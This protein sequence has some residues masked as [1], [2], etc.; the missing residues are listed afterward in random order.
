MAGLGNYTGYAPPPGTV[1]NDFSGSYDEWYQRVV[2]DLIRLYVEG[3]P[4]GGDPAGGGYESSTI[5]RPSYED[6][7]SA[8]KGGQGH[9][10]HATVQYFENYVKTYGAQSQW[11]KDHFGAPPERRATYNPDP[12]SPSSIQGT[13]AEREAAANADREDRQAFDAAEAEKERTFT[14]AEN[15]ADRK[16]SLDLDANATARVK[17]QIDSDWKIATMEDATRRY[18]AEGDWGT[19]KYIAELQETGALTRLQ[20]ELGQR[21]EELAQRAIEEKDRHHESMLALTLEVAKYDAE[22]SAQPRNWL[23]YAGW[24][25]T[26]NV[27]INGLTLAMAADM[28]PDTAIDP[29]EI[30]SSPAGGLTA[31]QTTSGNEQV[32]QVAPKTGGAQA[33]A[34]GLLSGASGGATGTS[35]ELEALGFKAQTQGAGGEQ[36]DAR[37]RAGQVAGIDLNSTDYSAIAR[38]LLGINTL[39]PQG[40]P[41]TAE[42]QAAYDATN[43]S[44]MAKTGTYG[45]YAGP[46]TNKFGMKINTQGGQEDY[47]NF[48]NLLPSQQDMRLAA[49]ESTGKWLPDFLQELQRSRPKGGVAGAASYG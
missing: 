41:S 45:A 29:G 18:I 10:S 47:R 8:K 14:A 19:Q 17:M 5:G 16:I 48:G 30:A 21:D 11:I 25:Q 31:L 13:Q 34:L 7:G 40:A 39:G 9:Y 44:G 38:K 27:V 35:T 28:V 46:T 2:N 20:L 3:G 15:A 36:G 24:L 12:N 33:E 23:A 37:V 32:T 1:T 49:V 26:R 4:E 43:T 42:L 22:L 6:F